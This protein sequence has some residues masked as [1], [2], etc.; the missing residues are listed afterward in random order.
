MS[1]L[2]KTAF[3]ALYGTSGTTFPDNTTQE[4][5]E[6]DI[7]QFGKD[8]ADSFYNKTNDAHTLIPQF[9]ASG[10]DT[11]TAT[12]SPAISSYAAGQ[13]FKILFTNANTG[14]ATLNLNGVG[15]AA[16]TKDGTTALVA[17]DI[18]AGSIKIL[19][20]DGTRF[21]IIGDGGGSGGGSGTVESVTGDG[22]D[23]TDP[24]NPVISFPDASDVAFT[25][26]SGISSTNVQ[27]AIEE[28]AAA[29]VTDIT[30]TDT[31]GSTITLN[32]N[33]QRQRIHVGS[34]SFATAKTI[35]MSNTT[36]SVSFVFMFEVTDV[37]AELTVPSDWI[38]DNQSFDG[39]K[40][41]PPTTGK[42]TCSGIFDGTEWS[43]TWSYP[44]N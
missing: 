18:K 11:Y 44:K 5:S 27:D 33:N 28:V 10:T 20:Y 36:S 34:A 1:Q 41:T 31:S 22:V 39:T 14:A 32:M 9:T 21:Q 17:D 12:P 3:E 15:A 8:I 25:P 24:A 23:N 38:S 16:I 2:S 37:A 40:W 42:Y 26:A 19:S 43:V 7:R 6:S 29:I 13:T 4:I 30:S 35:V